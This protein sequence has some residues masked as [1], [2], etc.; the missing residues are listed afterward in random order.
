M[1][2]DIKTTVP[3]AIWDA[4]KFHWKFYLEGNI[5]SLIG[6][7]KWLYE[8]IR[9]IKSS[10]QA[11]DNAIIIIGGKDYQYALKFAADNIQIYSKKY[12]YGK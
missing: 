10:G 12:S 9:Q 3:L 7:Q 4:K 8:G 5:E 11:Q 1:I 6:C 2:V